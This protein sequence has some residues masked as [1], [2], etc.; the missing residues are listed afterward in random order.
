M[1]LHVIRTRR[2]IKKR[3]DVMVIRIVMMGV[4]KRVV[5]S[6]SANQVRLSAVFQLPRHSVDCC[7]ECF[8][9]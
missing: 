7:T 4:M 9:R 3:T 8:Q 1:N 6:I 5:V 2:V